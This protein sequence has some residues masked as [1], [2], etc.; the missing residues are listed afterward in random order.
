[1]LLAASILLLALTRAEIVERMKA[2]V[3]TQ[4]DGLVQVYADCPEDMRREFQMPVASFA[5]EV[6]KALYR[7]LAIKPRRYPVSPVKVHLGDVRTNLTDVVTKVRTNGV[8][9][10]SRIYLESPGF[11]DLGRFR[12]ELIK[13][14]S[15]TVRGEE[16]TDAGAVAL[17]RRADPQFR[18]ADERAKLDDWLSGQLPSPTPEDD[19]ANLARMRKVLEPGVASRTDIRIFASRLYLYPVEFDLLF[20]GRFDCLSFREAVAC[21]KVDPHVR[22]AAFRKSGLLVAL[23]GG[24]G[25]RMSEAVKLYFEFLQELAKGEKDEKELLATLDLADAKLKEALANAGRRD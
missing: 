17:F 10:V 14:F 8:E 19:E 21:S 2:P 11:A 20:C 6:A 15:R 18:L 25:E 9:V 22:I 7:G 12:L 4:C 24:H 3:I 1:M 5:A 23:G 13:A 16:L